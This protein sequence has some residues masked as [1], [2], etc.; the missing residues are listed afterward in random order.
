MLADI[1]FGLTT[2]AVFYLFAR[3]FPDARRLWHSLMYASVAT[4]AFGLLTGEMFGFLVFGEH[5][6]L[7]SV[8]ILF[9][10]GHMAGQL[11][12][13]ALLI[14]VAHVN[15]GYLIGAYNEYLEH[16]VAEAVFAKLS[17]IVIEIGAVLAVATPYTTAGAAVAVAG[18]AM[19]YRGEHIEGV[20]EIPSL[21]SNILSYLR[22]FGVIMAV[23]ALAKVVNALAMP[24][25]HSGSILLMGLGVV[26]LVVGHTMNTFLKMMECGL[27][28]I[29]LHYVEF[30]TKFFEGG[31][32]YYRPFGSNTGGAS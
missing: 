8:P 15:L 29:R 14:G 3:K 5:G 1:G 13:I 32:T 11:V 31:G 10:R 9:H 18:V 24:L 21:L 25:F 30:F 6:I 19:L 26:I 20:V 7:S 23:L 2:F 12:T 22:I 28:A 17:W 4:I 16:G 27:Q